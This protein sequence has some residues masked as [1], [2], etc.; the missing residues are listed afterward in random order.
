VWNPSPE[1]VEKARLK[2]EKSTQPAK[3]SPEKAKPSPKRSKRK[4][5][6]SDDEEDARD[7]EEEH[8]L[9]ALQMAEWQQGYGEEDGEEEK[10]ET[11]SKKKPKVQ[12]VLEKRLAVEEPEWRSRQRLSRC[13][14]EELPR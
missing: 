8:V 4:R 14:Q 10:S 11:K 5:A 6:N 3:E 9:E 2:E 1:Y 7:E 13:Q 12:A